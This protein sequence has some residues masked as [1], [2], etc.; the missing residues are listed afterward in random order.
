M[1][2]TKSQLRNLIESY[3]LSEGRKDRDYIE[4]LSISEEDKKLYLDA[5]SSGLKIQEIGWIEKIRG[6]FDLFH[7]I[8]SVLEFKTEEFKQKVRVKSKRLNDPNILSYLDLSSFSSI[9]ELDSFIENI[10]VDL[11]SH[12]RNKFVPLETG[13]DLEIVGQVGPWTIILPKTIRGSVS[14]DVRTD[15]DTTWCTT[16]RSGQNLF[17]SYVGNDNDNAMLFYVM[18]YNR[19]PLKPIMKQGEHRNNDARMS[20][21]FKNSEPYLKG[22]DG[23]MSVDAANKGIT[24]DYL[25]NALGKYYDEVMRV[26]NSSVQKYNGVS[27]AIEILRKSAQSVEVLLSVIKDYESKERNSFIESVLNQS[28][29]SQDVLSYLS[30]DN[31]TYIRALVAKNPSTSPQRLE[32]LSNDSSEDVRMHVAKNP[33]TSPQILEKLSNDPNKVVRINVAKNPST[34]PQTLE[35]LSNDRNE[36]ARFKVAGN[37]STSPQTLEK[38]SNDSS[39]DV[40]MYVAGNPSTSPQ[41][42][43]KLLNDP[44]EVVRMHAV[45]NPS[46]SPQILEKLSNNPDDWA[47]DSI[48]K[49]PS[50]S[51]QILEKLSNDPNLNVRAQVAGNPSTSPQILEKLSNDPNKFVRT[52]AIKSLNLLRK[53]M[54]RESK[55][56]SLKFLL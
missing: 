42:L 27:P 36:W 34:S 44:N 3:L 32:K 26:L 10:N 48:A 1:I 19:T 8:Q 51:L 53:E 20:L 2:I 16:K 31:S 28:D 13:S 35:K 15:K 24:E 21:G 12:D 6:T 29:I 37:P 14:C 5:E 56:Y 54:L 40:R 25:R 43:E 9:Q 46:I 22:N 11:S 23:G 41:I 18:D 38:L 39:E 7:I 55:R 52:I 17:Y 50:T 49:N 4:N 45:E 33:S 47:R 30:N